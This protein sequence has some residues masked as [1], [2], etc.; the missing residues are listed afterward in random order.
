MVARR[1]LADGLS[2][3]VRRGGCDDNRFALYAV[4]EAGRVEQRRYRQP[5]GLVPV[6]DE[7]TDRAGRRLEELEIP[8]HHEEFDAGHFKI[9]DRYLV[10]L[11]R[12]INARAGV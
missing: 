12:L 6:N 2:P 1:A 4:G 9:D 5:R 8:H 11:P 10:V 7:R 3:R